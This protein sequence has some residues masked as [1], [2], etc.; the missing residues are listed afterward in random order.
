M[1]TL[2]IDLGG[3]SIK[4]AVVELGD[5]PRIL[6]ED[7]AATHAELG[8]DAVLDRMAELGRRAIAEA[9][10]VERVGVGAPGPLDLEGGRALSMTNLPGWESR[11]IVAQLEERLGL[12]VALINDARA[13]TLAELEAGAG[14]GC[15]DIVCFALGTGVGG[16]V[17]VDGKLL[18][19]LN[20][21][22]GEIGHQTI[23]P[24]G[25]PCPCGS[26]GCLEQYVSGPSIACAAGKATAEEAFAAA[27]AGDP[28]AAEALERAGTYL[29]IGIANVVLTVGPERVI[30][31]GGVAEAGDLL[32]GPAR[33]EFAR[34]NRMMPIERVEIVTAELGARAGAIGAVLW[35]A[36]SL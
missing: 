22:A 36:A 15:R 28:V 35:A 13:F 26:R 20:G 1:R 8:P 5:P 27:R 2:G 31:G 24:D 3:T 10:P 11:P 9:G 19:G 14:R 32:L 34:R 29:G 12:P 18:L 16:G 30:V 23:E 33:R 21:T 7:R 25:P 6:A 4:V 17:V